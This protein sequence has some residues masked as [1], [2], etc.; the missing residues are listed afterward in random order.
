MEIK[1]D[2]SISDN[3]E[4]APVGH[5][6]FLYSGEIIEYYSEQELLKDYKESVYSQGINAIKVKINKTKENSR[7]GLR[8]AVLNEETGEFGTDYTKEE[9]ERDYKKS[10][11]KRE[12]E[13]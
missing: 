4:K 5:L 3:I 13:R 2:Y 8:Y 7:H 11:I 10:L 9:Y 1:F 12:H 6:K